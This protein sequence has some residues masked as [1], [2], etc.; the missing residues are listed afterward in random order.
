MTSWAP[1]LRERGSQRAWSPPAILSRRAVAWPQCG[2]HSLL[3]LLVQV[4]QLLSGHAGV[5]LH[6]LAIDIEVLAVKQ[7]LNQLGAQLVRVLL[8]GHGC[9][10]AVATRLSQ[11]SSGCALWLQ[12]RHGS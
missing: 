11:P 9:C 3:N 10:H 8:R 7:V 6:I 12:C 4:L 1:Y 2:A 5:A